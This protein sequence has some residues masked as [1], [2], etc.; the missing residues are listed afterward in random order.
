MIPLKMRCS[1]A[2]L[3][4]K[5]SV[6]LER[7]VWLCSETPEAKPLAA[8]TLFQ[9]YEIRD[10]VISSS[11]RLH[12]V[13][14]TSPWP[15]LPHSNCVIALMCPVC[16]AIHEQR[17]TGR[18]IDIEIWLESSWTT[19]FHYESDRI[20]RLSGTR[21]VGIEEGLLFHIRGRLAARFRFQG[22]PGQV[23]LKDLKG[24]FRRIGHLKQAAILGGNCAFLDQY[25]QAQDAVPV[26]RTINHDA[27]LLGQLFRLNQG[28]HFKH[29]VQRAK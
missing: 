17:V 6:S 29:L 25:V 21:D 1:L 20:P 22:V 28:Q 16:S 4:M 23:C 5:S 13:G 2:S 26:S 19:R 15:V 27:D 10:P 12:Y 3:T 14:A 7:L 18:R 24:L 9:R 8:R 11:I